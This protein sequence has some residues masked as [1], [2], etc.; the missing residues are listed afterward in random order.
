MKCRERNAVR[1]LVARGR[2][3]C[4]SPKRVGLSHPWKPWTSQAGVDR[5]PQSRP[6]SAI[7][8]GHKHPEHARLREWYGNTFDPN[9]P[10]TDKRRLDV[11]KLAK[12]RKPKKAKA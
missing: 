9:T 8:G 10:D 4:G 6:F 7:P 1:K 12:R 11:L 3:V 2:W 5:L